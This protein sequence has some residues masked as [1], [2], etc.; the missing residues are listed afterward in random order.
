MAH[1][2]LAKE[3]ASEFVATLRLSDT[4]WR[5][6][7]G[8]LSPWIFRGQADARW[9]LQPS[10]WRPD[11]QAT[12]QPLLCG[13]AD[14]ATQL[15]E[16]M[17]ELDPLDNTIDFASIPAER[18]TQFLNQLLAE[19]TAIR[20][21]A[22]LAD[23]I[24]HPVP[25]LASFVC[26]M[27]W[28]RWWYAPLDDIQE[29]PKSLGLA[30]LLAQHHGIPTRLLDWSWNPLVA[31]LFAARDAMQL[32]TQPEDIS[33]WAADTSRLELTERL[34]VVKCERYRHTFLHAQHGL[35]IHDNKANHQFLRSGEWPAFED[36]I[37]A[38]DPTIVQQ[39]TLPVGE[40][41]ALIKLLWTERVTLAHIMPTLDNVV[42]ALKERWRLD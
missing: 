38:V 25:A 2:V 34:T 30:M 22:E 23:S 27:D 41:P 10:A 5:P 36:V 39:I 7:S 15:A 17:S 20:E 33:V 3:R 8:H 32:S 29:E 19:I 42:T 24:G 12:L 11:G 16:D 28:V 1:V 6:V 40:A 4:R 35:S 9:R 13:T 21:F 14:E 37:S 26:P 18:I 31:A